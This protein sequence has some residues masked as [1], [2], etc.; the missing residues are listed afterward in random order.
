MKLSDADLLDIVRRLRSYM[1]ATDNVHNTLNM[2]QDID[3]PTVIKQIQSLLV[4]IPPV[5]L[6]CAQALRGIEATRQYR[7]MT[8]K[9]N[10]TDEDED[11]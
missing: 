1:S 6:R 11:G 3:D 9:F 8:K 5:T 10:I 2:A 4:D 7:D